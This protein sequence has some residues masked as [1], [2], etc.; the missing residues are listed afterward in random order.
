[1]DDIEFQFMKEGVGEDFENKQLKWV[2][3]RKGGVL[4][5]FSP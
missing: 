2:E 1:M 4:L 3:K 5:F